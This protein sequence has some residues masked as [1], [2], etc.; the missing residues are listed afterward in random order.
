MNNSKNHLDKTIDT[1][2]ISIGAK[3]MVRYYYS[4][5]KHYCSSNCFSFL[6][7]HSILTGYTLA[8]VIMYISFTELP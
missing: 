4:L 3:T 7:T 1:A 6:N 8:K 5:K 2:I